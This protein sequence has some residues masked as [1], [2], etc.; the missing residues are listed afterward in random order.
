MRERERE[1]LGFE[2]EL[3]KFSFKKKM[4]KATNIPNFQAWKPQ[5][6]LFQQKRPQHGY[7]PTTTMLYK[8]VLLSSLFRVFWGNGIPSP[9]KAIKVR[10][11]LLLLI[12]RNTNKSRY[13]IGI[14]TNI[15][16]A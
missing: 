11:Y 16:V 5:H 1:S 15:L 10:R 7:I 9:R 3:F 12:E 14:Y 13:E 2:I 6:P 8:R 4:T